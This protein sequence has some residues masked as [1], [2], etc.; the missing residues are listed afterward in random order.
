[1]LM[2]AVANADQTIYTTSL[3]NGWHDW[4]W[5]TVNTVN[6][7]PVHSAP[8]SI[9]VTADAWGAVYFEHTAFDPSTF[10]NVS[11]WINGGSSGGQRLQLQAIYNGYAVSSGI[12]LAPLPTNGWTHLNAPM[13]SLVPPGQGLIDGLWIQ[14]RT[15]TPQPTF[16]VDDILLQSD[17]SPPPPPSTNANVTVLVDALANRHPI[18]P[19]VY[20][21]AFAS[22][23]NQLSDLNV[24]LHRSGGN[25][26]T[27]YNWQLNASSRAADWYFESLP[28]P[29]STPGADGDDF[30]RDSKNG[31]AQP[32]LTI[33]IIGWVAKL[34][35]GRAGLASYATNK[36]GIQTGQDPYWSIAGNGVLPGNIEITNNDPTDANVTA[37]T[38]FQAAWVQHLTNRWSSATNGGLRFYLMDNEWSLWHSTHRDVHPVGATMNEVRDKFCDYAAMVKGIDPNALVAGPEEWGWSGFFYSGYDLQYGSI[39]GW[40]TLPDRIAHTNQDFAPW[41]LSQVNQRSQAAGK[42]LIDVFSLHY[43][44][45]GGEA[46]NNDISVATQLRRNRSTRSLWDSN[47]V[48]ESW[49]NDKVMLIPRMKNWVATNYPG[50]LTGIT[51]YNWGADDYMNGATAQADVL[52][53]FGRESLDIATR[54]TCPASNSPAYKAFKMY[55]NYD[56]NR[57]TFG[58]ISVRATAPNPDAVAAFA[59]VRTNDGVLTVM[60]INKDLTNATP[61]TLR[62]TN[63]LSAGVAR[64]WQLAANVLTNLPDVAFTNN[65]FS[66]T[67]P[68]QSIT[69]LVVPSGMFHLRVATNH[70]AGQFGF[71]L[72]G[73]VGQTYTLQSST[74]MV[75][76]VTFN[77]NTLA[78]NSVPYSLS[79]T[80]R[81]NQFYR[82]MLGQ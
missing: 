33:P 25:A 75:H 71:W 10:T 14:D 73:A 28:S 80:G 3:V 55:R 67:V 9:S 69:L 21:V 82:G 59:A 12:L 34:G 32:M 15:G 38:N 22:G 42:R 78:S 66:N 79:L 7:S 26:T 6:T 8:A 44:P 64:R 51:E 47:Y 20:G 60:V 53:I 39:H 54:W 57:S 37:N 27:R 31:G 18:N 29:S 1:M 41:F 63:F 48:D 70:V 35:S 50:I 61:V 40:G 74:D 4:S 23:S 24:P 13:S 52:G 81:A 19:F 30:V 77:T 45:Q 62:I 65:V 76:W 16:Y 36:Y 49:I 56:G 46:L 43:Y 58:D 2:F 68:P 11:L 17:D 5:A 72:D